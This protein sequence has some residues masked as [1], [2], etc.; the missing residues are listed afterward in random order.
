MIIVGDK[1][2]KIS[3]KRSDKVEMGKIESKPTVTAVKTK[4]LFA[5]GEKKL[6]LSIEYEYNTSYSKDTNI[7]LEGSLFI[8]G[9]E[10]KLKEVEKNFKKSKKLDNNLAIPVLRRIFELG[11]TN[12]VLI[13]KTLGLPAPIQ[14]P[15]VVS[16]E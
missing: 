3:A 16:K 14:L 13:S 8:T 1:V 4:D 7:Q 6:G 2:T 5:A 11:M 9:D 12:S 10:K 15:K